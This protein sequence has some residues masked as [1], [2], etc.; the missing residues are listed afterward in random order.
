MI[1]KEYDDRNGH[2]W[3]F[4]DVDNIL[5]LAPIL[6]IVRSLR[7]IIKPFFN[8]FKKRTIKY[9][10]MYVQKIMYQKMLK[11]IKLMH[12]RKTTKEEKKLKKYI[13][14]FFKWWFKKDK[15]YYDLATLWDGKLDAEA[16]AFKK[17]KRRK[18]YILT[19]CEMVRVM[20][21]CPIHNR[22]KCGI[23]LLHMPK[24]K[25]IWNCRLLMCLM[26]IWFVFYGNKKFH[27]LPHQRF[28]LV[29]IWY[30]FY[31]NKKWRIFISMIILIWYLLWNKRKI[32]TYKYWSQRYQ[33]FDNN[34]YYNEFDLHDEYY[35]DLLDSIQKDYFEV[36]AFRIRALKYRYYYYFR[37]YSNYNTTLK[38]EYKIYNHI[39]ILYQLTKTL[40]HVL[41]S[42]DI[43]ISVYLTRVLNVR[44]HSA[45]RQYVKG[46]VKTLVLF[47]WGED[48]KSR[49]FEKLHIECENILEKAFPPFAPRYD[50]KIYTYNEV[51]YKN[52]YDLYSK[53]PHIHIFFRY[54]LKNEMWNLNWLEVLETLDWDKYYS[55]YSHMDDFKKLFRKI[56]INK[57]RNDM[58]IVIWYLLLVEN[59]I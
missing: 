29:L 49:N 23:H 59:I 36:F 47:C 24:V 25:T 18:K 57:D 1:K 13:K 30:A 2:G 15:K 22:H 48:I 46:L 20:L 19:H 10:P 32:R 43:I 5:E 27:I 16:K 3:G 37:D 41:I 58:L 14:S 9:L 34:L 31:G 39:W 56:K 55:L 33:A 26:F 38:K 28:N 44:Y 8:Y 40:N 11:Q 35:H 6:K 51:W 4:I 52:R 17:L 21:N 12:R 7:L 42:L 50:K 54:D 53:Q 45:N